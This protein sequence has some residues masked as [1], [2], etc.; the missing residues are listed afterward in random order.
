[1]KTI[2]GHSVPTPIRCDQCKKVRNECVA[3]EESISRAT[4]RYFLCVSCVKE[5]EQR[6]LDRIGADDEYPS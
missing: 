2:Y 4:G 1:M 3:L 5:N 6:L